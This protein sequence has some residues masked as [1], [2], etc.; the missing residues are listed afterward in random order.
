MNALPLRRGPGLPIFAEDMAT[1]KQS[2]Q[3]LLKRGVKMIH[4]ADGHPFP[5]EV[6]QQAIFAACPLL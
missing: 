3:K 5:A 1:L 4:P 6:I 2:W